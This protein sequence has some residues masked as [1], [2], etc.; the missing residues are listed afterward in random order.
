VPMIA[1]YGSM[2]LLLVVPCAA[3]AL[4]GVLTLMYARNVSSLQ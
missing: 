4:K 2:D 1:N 3:F